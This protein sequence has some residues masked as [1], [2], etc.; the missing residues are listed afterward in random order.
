MIS[1][2]DCSV[3]RRVGEFTKDCGDCPMGRTVEPGFSLREGKTGGGLCGLGNLL[4]SFDVFVRGLFSLTCLFMFL[5]RLGEVAAKD[6][7]DLGNSSSFRDGILS[8][9]RMCAVIGDFFLP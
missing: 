4:M 6:A 7:A 3:G 9:L 5:V 2:G 1:R 8:G